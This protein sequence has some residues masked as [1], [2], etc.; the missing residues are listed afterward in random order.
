MLQLS[1]IDGWFKRSISYQKDP[2]ELVLRK[3]FLLVTN[4]IAIIIFS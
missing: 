1:A 2:S 4:I 3:K